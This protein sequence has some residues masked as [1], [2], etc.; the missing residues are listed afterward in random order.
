[1]KPVKNG[2]LI[3]EEKHGSRYFRAETREQLAAACLKIVKE[4]HEAG[5]YGYST[6]PDYEKNKP[7]PP[8]CMG[9]TKDQIEGGSAFN[10]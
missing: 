4:R 7:K 3:F 2:I 6:D 8:D 10:L 1:M 9:M 5:W